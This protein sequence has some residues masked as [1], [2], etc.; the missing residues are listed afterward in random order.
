[1]FVFKAQT[2]FQVIGALEV[3]NEEVARDDDGGVSQQID[4][5][6]EEPDIV[7]AFQ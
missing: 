6:A 5:E 4:E 1:M 3:A 2:C 7:P